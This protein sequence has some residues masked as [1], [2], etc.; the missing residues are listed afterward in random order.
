MESLFSPIITPFI[1]MFNMREKSLEIVDFFRY[2]TVEVPGVGDVC[3][4]ALMDIG[5]HE[6]HTWHPVKPCVESARPECS[7]PNVI[8]NDK[9]EPSLLNFSLNNPNRKPPQNSE[10]TLYADLV[11]LGPVIYEGLCKDNG[12][13]L[14]KQTEAANTLDPQQKPGRLG[15]FNNCT[16]NSNLLHDVF[17]LDNLSGWG[18]NPTP[19]YVSS[20]SYY[21]SSSPPS[22]NGL[23]DDTF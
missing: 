11:S 1:L 13:N 16:D 12:R 3:S 18:K 2:F 8:D 4:F 9:T 21:N 17:Y 7:P 14:P 23:E 5:R 15:D 20:S 22:L 19:T 10:T 6:N